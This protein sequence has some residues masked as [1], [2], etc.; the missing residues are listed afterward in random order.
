MQSTVRYVVLV[1][2]VG[3]EAAAN[4][5]VQTAE[6][7]LT[8][9][10][11]LVENVNTATNGAITVTQESVSGDVSGGGSIPSNP[12][13]DA[14]VSLLR[15]GA[16]N[17]QT[18]VTFYLTA[19]YKGTSGSAQEGVAITGVCLCVCGSCV[20]CTWKVCDTLSLTLLAPWVWVK[21]GWRTTKVANG[22]CSYCGDQ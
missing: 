13:Q 21:V 10:G 14:K 17:L 20:H 7:N 8:M 2:Y 4:T 6:T 5:L 12:Q 9:V 1:I 3:G 22:P 15:S 19:V 11:N 16:D 18:G